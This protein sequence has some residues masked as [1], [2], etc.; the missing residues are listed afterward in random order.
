MIRKD[1]KVCGTGQQEYPAFAENMTA[2][3]AATWGASR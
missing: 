3:S 1:D 2:L